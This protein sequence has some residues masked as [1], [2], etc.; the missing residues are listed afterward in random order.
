MS[1]DITLI[2]IG[3]DPCDGAVLGISEH[4]SLLEVSY[5]Q[6]SALIIIEYGCSVIHCVPGDTEATDGQH[7]LL[8]SPSC[9]LY[10]CLSSCTL[11]D[12]APMDTLQSATPSLD[13]Q[14]I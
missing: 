13:I 5:K 8:M 11:G 1:E 3:K 4:V 9:R 10:T 7:K 2:L 12:P 6:I 14:D